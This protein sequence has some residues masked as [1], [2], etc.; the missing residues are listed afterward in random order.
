MH[1]SDPP[2]VGT[3]G[4]TGPSNRPRAS[5]CRVQAS[6]HTMAAM[7]TLTTPGGTMTDDYL[8]GLRHELNDDPTYRLARNAVTKVGADEAALNRDIVASTDWSFSTWIDDWSVTNQK[9][10]GRCWMFAALNLFRAGVMKRMNVKKFEFS[11]NYT[12]FWDKF[13]RANWFLECIIET[14]SRQL[15]DRYVAFLLDYPLDDG[16]QWNMFVNLV[17]RHGLVPKDMMPESQSSSNTMRMNAVCKGFLRGFARDLRVAIEGGA[18]QDDARAIKDTQL[19]TIWR[20]LCT[21]LGEPPTTFMWQYNDKDRNFHREG[22]MT[23]RQFAERYVDLPIEEYVCLVHD[24]RPEHPFGQTYTVEYLGNIV[25]GERVVYLNV[26]MD[27][28]KRAA[29][30]T[31]EDGEPVWFGCDVGKQFQ[32]QVGLW[33]AN[34][35]DFDSL[36]GQADGLNKNDR[37]QYHHTAMTH[38]MLFTGVDVLD[39]SPRRWRVENSWGDE[40]VGRKG[41]QTMNDSWFDEYVFEIAAHRSRLSEDLQAALATEPTVLAPWD[42]M[43]A[44]ARH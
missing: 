28:I 2:W 9:K 1:T 40:G 16:G 15:E 22:E 32:R 36:Y 18:S 19:A 44:L 26:D 27:T 12:L 13:E 37:L 11:Q 43:G 21:H 17:K 5:F 14:A 30:D 6:P 29:I 3:P 39:G 24:P 23:P 20:V 41:F 35:M 33:D 4:C 31:L 10:S 34:L 25:G 38:A 7:S 42:P 8:V